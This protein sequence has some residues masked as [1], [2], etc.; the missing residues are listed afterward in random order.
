[1]GA[2]IPDHLNKTLL[3]VYRDF[4]KLPPRGW[5]RMDIFCATQH[6]QV[7]PWVRLLFFFEIRRYEYVG[8]CFSLIFTV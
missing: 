1:M 2:V 3:R 6:A 8:D 7:F 4:V 5:E